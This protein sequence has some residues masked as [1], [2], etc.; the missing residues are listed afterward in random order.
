MAKT[1]PLLLSGATVLLSA[2]SVVLEI[3]RAIAWIASGSPRHNNHYYNRNQNQN[4]VGCNSAFAPQAQTQTVVLFSAFDEST[5]RLQEPQ[6]P[7]AA[8]FSKHNYSMGP[9]EDTE[10]SNEHGLSKQALPA[11]PMA[12]EERLLSDHAA[13]ESFLSETAV[14]PPQPPTTESKDSKSQTDGASASSVSAKRSVPH[15]L[16][17][18]NIK[19][20]ETETDEKDANDEPTRFDTTREPETNVAVDWKSDRPPQGAGGREVRKS[21]G[22]QHE[23]KKSTKMRDTPFIAEDVQREATLINRSVYEFNNNLVNLAYSVIS[24]LYPTS[25][26]HPLSVASFSSPSLDTEYNEEIIVPERK[27]VLRFEQFY[28]FETVARIPYFA[29]LFVLH[30]RETL[31][32]RGAS[33]GEK[34]NQEEDEEPSFSLSNHQRIETMRAH[35]FQADNELHHMLIM[36][37][38]GGDYIREIDRFLANTMAFFYYWFVVLVFSWNEQ[39]A[40]HLNEV[41]EDYSYKM[42]E[43]V[44]NSARESCV[45]LC[46]ANR[47]T[48]YVES[49]FADSRCHPSID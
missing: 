37:A 44:S 48:P 21:G 25:P 40:Y 3:D 31:G 10:G 46:H 6:P 8:G 36:E 49:G 26:P 38:L 33:K 11:E 5:E 47:M 18:S 12:L 42:Y 13:L 4:R 45:V 15:F 32:D 43:K 35:Y 20:K 23:T 16:R 34:K 41:V 30:H 29:Y 22:S 28:V 39:A 9:K 14:V 2:S 1:R 24:F 19:G 27:T 17:S 7:P